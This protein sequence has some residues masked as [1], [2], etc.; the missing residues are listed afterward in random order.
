MSVSF[1]SSNTSS[2]PALSIY[3]MVL[4]C[5]NFTDGEI[6][7]IAFI[8]T[9]ILFLLPLYIIVLYLLVQQWRQQQKCS[10]ALSHS[11]HFTCHMVLMELIGVI[12]SISFFCGIHIDLS[13]LKAVGFFLL[14]IG[15][16]GQAFLHFLTCF[17]RYLAVVHPITYRSLRNSKG[18]QIRNVTSGISWLLSFA[19]QGFLFLENLSLYGIVG[20]LYLVVSIAN[21]SFCSF[22]VLLVLICPGPGEGGG[23]RNK[24]DKTKQ[25][26]FF[27]ITAILVVLFIKFIG[28]LVS[29]QT[30]TS[31]QEA[32]NAVCGAIGAALWFSLPS[33]LVLPL[34]Y[35]HRAGKLGCMNNHETKSI[36]D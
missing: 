36:H 28:Y 7:F 24:I 9:N 17:E 13:Q 21:V 25:R 12:G 6:Q 30:I 3:Y 35:L 20:V 29:N 23:N 15:L 31:K 34:L 11:D 14:S 19:I 32:Q 1:S 16:N 22:S 10:T 5:K 26:A 33:S 27:T 2:A 18:I 4:N 8:A